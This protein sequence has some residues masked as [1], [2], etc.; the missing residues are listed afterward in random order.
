MQSKATTPDQYLA[1]L[2]EDRREAMSKLRE[3][4][5]Q[6]L[7]KGFEEQISFGMLGYVVPHSIYPNGYHCN[8]DRKSVV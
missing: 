3:V 2:Q 5:L 4:T 1:E 7:P 6:N 8:P